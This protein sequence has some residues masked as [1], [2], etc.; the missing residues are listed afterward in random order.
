MLIENE[1]GIVWCKPWGEGQG[2]YV[3]VSVDQFDPSFHRLLSDEADMN[4]NGR[5]SVGELRD[6][7]TAAGVA[8]KPA[9]KRSELQALYDANKVPA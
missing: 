4:G 8:F 6:W 5:L 7:L 3:R 9:A 2:D 1:P